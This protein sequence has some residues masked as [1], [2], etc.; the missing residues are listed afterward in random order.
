[1]RVRRRVVAA[2]AGGLLVALSVVLAGSGVGASSPRLNTTVG[3]AGC[4]GPGECM[5][6]LSFGDV[7]LGTHMGPQ[8]FW[9]NNDYPTTV[10]VDLST[11]VSLSGPGASDYRLTVPGCAG[12][13]TGTVTMTP[14]YS[15]LMN[16]S[17]YP[18]A[19]GDRSATMTINPSVG[20]PG[21]INISGTGTQ[22]ILSF[23]E[24]TLGTY[25]GPD[26]FSLQN[27]GSSTDTVDLLTDD[28]S[29]S[30]PGR[31]TTW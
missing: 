7:P 14:G 29:I 2:M 28:V 19:L 21:T 18:G 20:A 4:S 6:S 17:F 23:G 9:L 1:M 11:G 24:T 5:A 27:D 26:T 22:N 25:A 30:G 3:T 12:S 15:C 8:S 10:T 13:S 16:V 31:T